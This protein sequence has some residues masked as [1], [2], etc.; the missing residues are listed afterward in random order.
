MACWAS[1]GPSWLWLASDMPFNAILIKTWL[2]WGLVGSGWL[3][4][5]PGAL[6]GPG[7]LQTCF[8]MQLN[9]EVTDLGS[10]WLR[11]AFWAS[12]GP[13][14]PLLC[15]SGSMGAPYILFF[16]GTMFDLGHPGPLGLWKPFWGSPGPVWL[17][18]GSLH[19][20]YLK[21]D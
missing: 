2:N 11:V 4:G 14:W 5:P 3:V 17:H 18:G 12:W 6:R 20:F 16:F 10:G 8:L 9:K 13:S 7:W 1:W 19:S 21:N 15:L